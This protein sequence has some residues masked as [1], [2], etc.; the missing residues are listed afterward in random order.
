MISVE[1]IESRASKL[2]ERVLSN[3]DP[4]DHRLVFLQWATSLEILLFDEGGEKVGRL[5][6]VFKIAYSTRAQRCWRRSWQYPASGGP[7][8][9]CVARSAAQLPFSR[10]TGPTASPQ[11][12][13][14]RRTSSGGA[15]SVSGRGRG[16]GCLLIMLAGCLLAE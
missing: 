8:G 1:S 7:R 13:P 12:C 4:E 9:Q 5:L 16:G 14:A 15:A 2:I 10:A 6:Y 3:R 11:V